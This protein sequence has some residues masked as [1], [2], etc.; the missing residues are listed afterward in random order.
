[1]PAFF[2]PAGSHGDS[3]DEFFTRYLQGQRVGR[4]GRPVDI[5]RLL[6]K[7]THDV[8]AAA[9]RFAVERGQTEVDALH[10]LRTMLGEDPAA[11]GVRASGA[12]PRP[13]SRPWTSA[14][15]LPSRGRTRRPRP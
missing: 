14:C 5:T 10:V 6:S 15:P 1:M 12:D 13:S 2:G 3:F 7:R 11:A 9:A 8:I 4:Q